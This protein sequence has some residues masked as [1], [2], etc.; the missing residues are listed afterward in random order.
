VDDN[1]DTE[2]NVTDDS[3]DYNDDDFNDTIIVDHEVASA[4]SLTPQAS[5]GE[6]HEDVSFIF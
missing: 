6:D 2:G 3:D 4:L 1:K 5:S